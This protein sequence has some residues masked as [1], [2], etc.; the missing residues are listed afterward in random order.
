MKGRIL[1]SWTEQEHEHLSKIRIRI[2]EMIDSGHDR[3]DVYDY[4]SEQMGSRV[5]S[6]VLIFAGILAGEMLRAPSVR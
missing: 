3:R 6:R 4:I 1:K 5:P 2:R